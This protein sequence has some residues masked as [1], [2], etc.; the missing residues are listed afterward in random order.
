[1]TTSPKFA[2]FLIMGILALSGLTLLTSAWGDTGDKRHG[3]YGKMSRCDAPGKGFSHHQRWRGPGHLAEKLSAAETA[4]GIRANQVDAWR[5][6]TDAMLAV[7]QRPPRSNSDGKSEPFARAQ[8]LA[9]NTIARAKSAE[10]LLKAIE[11]L[12]SKLTPEQLAK[13]AELEARLRPHHRGPPPSFDEP[14]P[15]AGAKPNAPAGQDDDGPAPSE[16]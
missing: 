15:D 9:D 4:I 7:T 10:D 8:Q 12:R 14:T 2:P 11:V 1:M 5:D 13:V 16:Q 3:Q 6:F